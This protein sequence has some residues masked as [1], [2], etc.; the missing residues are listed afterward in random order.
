[1]LFEDLAEACN[2]LDSADQN[3]RKRKDRSVCRARMS[4]AG[5]DGEIAVVGEA[6][7]LR[8]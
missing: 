8:I 6:E 2:G 4:V 5:H 3:F 1:M 7:D